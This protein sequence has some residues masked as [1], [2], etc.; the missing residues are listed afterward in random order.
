[1]GNEHEYKSWREVLP[2]DWSDKHYQ[3]FLRYLDELKKATDPSVISQELG[4]MMKT[5]GY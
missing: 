5:R 3:E 1:M 2:R 4:R